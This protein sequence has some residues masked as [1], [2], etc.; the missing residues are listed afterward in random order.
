MRIGGDDTEERM[1]KPVLL[2]PLALGLAGCLGGD[3]SPGELRG[4]LTIY[5]SLPRHGV[6]A[7]A[8]RAAA[9]GQ[10]L[11]IADAG[12]R[13]G[14]RRVRLVLLSS[15]EPDE[16]LWDPDSVAE[17]A[18]TAADDPSAIAYL[19][20]LDYGASAIS[21]PITNDAGMVQVSP[22]DGLT[23]LTRTPPGRPRS[24]PERLYPSGRRTFA[25][26]TPSDLLQAEA[27]VE[28]A[29]ASGRRR[30]AVVFDD[31]VY[32]RELAGQVVARARRAGVITVRSEEFRHDPLAVPDLVRRLA[33][34]RPQTI[35]YAGVAGPGTPAL[36]AELRAS[37]PRVPLLASGG[38]LAGEREGRVEAAPEQVEAVTPI[39]PRSLA[40]PSARRLLRR[41][42]RRWGPAVAR[43][44]ALYGFESARLVLEAIDGAGPSRSGV[45]RE[46]FRRP[47]RHSVLGRYSLHATGEPT[48]RRLALYRLESGRPVFDRV[49]P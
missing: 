28:R 14:G 38:L 41:I 8:G 21:L 20:E 12:E 4:S 7:A 11:A 48:V 13:A 49:L 32:G 22:L 1:W 45:V 30:M 27:L 3:E 46:V 34:S 47:R 31:R 29:R 36:L 6:S 37:L 18:H 23:S 39:L 15:T 17:N 2:L 9:A 26:L 16:R 43:P 44:E 10:R 35:V 42:E 19:G 25:R 5:S 33:K 24:I 40:S